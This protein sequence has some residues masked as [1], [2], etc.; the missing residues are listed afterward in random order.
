VGSLCSDHC[1]AFCLVSG[2]YASALI[3][4]YVQLVSLPFTSAICSQHVTIFECCRYSTS[5]KFNLEADLKGS[6]QL[7]QSKSENE[8]T[9]AQHLKISDSNYLAGSKVKPRS[10]LY[11]LRK[12]FLK[13]RRLTQSIF[14]SKT[15]CVAFL[16][17]KDSWPSFELTEGILRMDDEY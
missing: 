15:S 9:T 2:G 7:A 4:V 11:S 3:L 10:L 14:Q 13:I 12:M 1:N 5:V 8:A 6:E 16:L 17:L